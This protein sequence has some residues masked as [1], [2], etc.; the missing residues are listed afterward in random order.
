M[1]RVDRRPAGAGVGAPR[2]AIEGEASGD[3]AGDL[4]ARVV[5][6]DELDVAIR[7]RA[8]GC[9]VLDAEVGQFESAIDT[10]QLCLFGERAA[11]L[12]GAHIVGT[13]PAVEVGLVVPLQFVVQDDTRDGA[14]LN[15]DALCLGL[16]KAIQLG[17]VC[18]FPR[19]DESRVIL[20]R[21]TTVA[22]RL[23]R[24][25]QSLAF[26]CQDTDTDWLAI[27]HDLTPLDQA[28]GFEAPEV[29]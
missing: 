15:T 10:Q 4:G 25:D 20:L 7:Q 16:V 28:V 27:D 8:L 6:G 23:T 11:F 1:M 22:R 2:G 18:D 9:L 21:P 19:L 3:L 29:G 14:T 17:V 5:F 24:G 13:V 26:L 12:L